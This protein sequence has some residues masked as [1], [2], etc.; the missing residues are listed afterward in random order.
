M[1]AL[2]GS[3]VRVTGCVITWW[4]NTK[5]ARDVLPKLQ[6]ALDARGI[7]LYAHAIPYEDRIEQAHLSMVGGGIKTIFGFGSNEAA[8]RYKDL[9]NEL[10]QEV[11]PHVNERHQ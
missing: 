10:I 5:S 7:K 3:G 4:R 6:A 8:A 9:L 1:R 11:R 2:V